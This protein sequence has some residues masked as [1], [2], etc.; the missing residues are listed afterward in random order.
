MIFPVNIRTRLDP[1]LDPKFHGNCVDIVAASCPLADLEA[2][3]GVGLRA[4]AQSVRA[5]VSGWS[6]ANWESWLTMACGLP[7]DQAIC[8]NPLMLLESRNIA[9]NDYSKSQSHTLDWG[10]GLG[11]IARTRYMKPAG[12]HC[13]LLLAPRLC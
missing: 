12:K 10:R 9:F 13:D 11:K 3:D 5:A 4:A 6:Q 1:P 8:P 2:S 7:D